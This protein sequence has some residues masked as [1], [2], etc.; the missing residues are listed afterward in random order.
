M[1]RVIVVDDE[2]LA[3]QR[4]LNLL[5]AETDMRVVAECANGVEALQ[6]I[7]ALRPELLFL[8]VQMPELG[9]FELLQQLGFTQPLP[10]IIFVTA[11]DQYALRAFDVHALD[12]LLKPFDKARFQQSLQRARSQ[13]GLRRQHGFQERLAAFMDGWEKTY[14]QRLAI[15][16]QGRVYL[17]PVSEIVWIEAAGNHVRF[18]DEQSSHLVRKTLKET[19]ASLDPRQFLRIH[20][21]II[22]N[23]TCIKELQ[24]WSRGEY[25]VILNGGQRLHS[26]RTYRSQIETFLDSSM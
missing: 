1:I 23:T 24:P 22:V 3:R 6:A 11:Y 7:N 16:S 25:L 18:H 21:S 17:L 13:I 2:L 12:Y 14:P 15:R 8:D 26:S 5:A 4:I 10:N 9:G 19:A 20:R